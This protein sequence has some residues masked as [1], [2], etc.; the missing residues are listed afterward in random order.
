MLELYRLIHFEL[1]SVDHFRY[2]AGVIRSET[3]EVS[4][5][6]GDTVSMEVQEPLGVVGQIIPWNFPLLMAAWKL[7]PALA[8]GGF[9]A[10]DSIN[11]RVSNQ[12]WALSRLSAV[13]PL[14]AVL[15]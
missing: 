5:L 15:V 2:F 12:V 3:G 9:S 4:D 13:S 6:D 7:A 10:A 14:Q 11:P 8:A 1:N